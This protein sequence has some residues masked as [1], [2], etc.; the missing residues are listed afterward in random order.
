MTIFWITFLNY[1]A[2]FLLLLLPF[3]VHFLFFSKK[4]WTFFWNIS[5]LKEASWFFSLWKIIKIL[6][7]LSF[8]F[9]VLLFSNPN[10]ST[11][12]TL[13]SSKWI[14]IQIVFDISYS[15]LAKDFAPN[16]INA[17]KEILKNFV[18]KL[19]NDRLWLILYSWKPFLFSPLT[20]DY[21]LFLSKIDDISVESIKQY[22]E[23]LAWTATWD[24]LLLASNYFDYSSDREKVIIL[25]TDWNVSKWV[26]TSKVAPYIAEKNIK[27][28]WIW[29]WWESRIMV[30][31]I[32]FDVEWLNP[33]TLREIVEITWWAYF[34]AT[35]NS[36]LEKIFE[37]ISQLEK[38]EIILE[39]VINYTKY[40]WPF[41]FVIVFLLTILLYLYRKKY[42]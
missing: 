8:I 33:E 21:P 40:Y 6:W 37:L 1:Y 27:V 5:D 4:Y 30:W 23:N 20:L 15:M 7:T 28:Y 14:D 12:N 17:S 22:S 39:N 13:E 9:F 42:V 18:S 26:E 19:E 31:E 35:E 25:I 16:R 38:K 32:G 3:L 10:L 36:S 29:I 41:Q 11:K 24:A 2:L 34:R